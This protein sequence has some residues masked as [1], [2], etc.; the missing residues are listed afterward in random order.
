MPR[1]RVETV[2]VMRKAGAAAKYQSS[3]LSRWGFDR[4]SLQPP[5]RCHGGWRHQP[6]HAAEGANEGVKAAAAGRRVAVRKRPRLFTG[7]FRPAIGDDEYQHPLERFIG[8]FALF[9]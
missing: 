9:F 4:Y 8:T 3:L 1:R 2:E 5:V 6:H 7:Q